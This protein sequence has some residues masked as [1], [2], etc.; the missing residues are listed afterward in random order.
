MTPASNDR[1]ISP[2]LEPRLGAPPEKSEPEPTSDMGGDFPEDYRDEMREDM[3]DDTRLGETR[4]DGNRRQ[5]D[6]DRSEDAPDGNR[7]A[8][9]DSRRDAGRDVGRNGGREGGRWFR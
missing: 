4:V 2:R 1:D 3:P 7:Y 5:P 8:D 9:R 6:E